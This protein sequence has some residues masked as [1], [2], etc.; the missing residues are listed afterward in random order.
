MW[1]L[2]AAACVDAVVAG[3][4]GPAPAACNAPTYLGCFQDPYKDPSGE[5]HR[6]LTEQVATKDALMDVERCIAL[7]CKSGY[8]KGS[9]AGVEDGGDCYCDDGFG[10]YTIPR[11]TTCTTTCPGNPG[12][13]CGGA[14]AMG[15]VTI[16]ACPSDAAQPVVPAWATAAEQVKAGPAL[17]TCPSS[18]TRCPT[19]DT[20]CQGRGPDSYKVAGGYGCSPPNSNSTGCASGSVLKGNK[21]CC[22]PGPS[23]I[24]TT[25]PNVLI[26]GDSVSDGY[27]SYVRS[28]LNT[29][30]NVGHGPD[31]SGGG[32]ADGV[33][34][35]AQ[36]TKYFV[37]TPLYELPPWDVITFNYGLHDGSDSN[38]TYTQGITH[39][40]D[41][42]LDTAKLANPS[43]PSRLVYFQTT[44]PGG[45][46][47]VPGEPV[48]PS[49]KRVIELN[50]IA[51][52]VMG[53]RGITV[54]D[55]YATMTKCGKT[56]SGCKPHCD[57][58]GYQ[59]LVDNAI[60]P[61]IKKALTA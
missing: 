33:L 10:P 61:A 5:S 60:I 24:S 25:L 40:A 4:T 2:V 53:A 3:T 52:R 57:G 15:V 47:S 49:D 28:G 18:C 20:C 51:A 7:C 58:P 19:E 59:Y 50:A 41:Q 27:T 9:L 26:I 44:I 1:A 38:A 46:N 55:L 16:N 14:G 37:R 32:C 34:Y 6:V 30:A 17:Q 11:S 21:C 35:G 31:N 42:L 13:P 48:S 12:T 22:G 39:I 36:C 45:A 56:C 54:V 23:T 43:K 29:T 8:A